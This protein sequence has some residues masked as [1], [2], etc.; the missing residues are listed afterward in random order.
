MSGNL[1]FLEKFT[2]GDSLKMK[3]YI[4]LYLKTAPILFES[5]ERNI[6]DQ[7]W[8]KVSRDAHSLKPQVMYMGLDSLSKLLLEVELKA[9][10]QDTLL[11]KE[12][13]EKA[14]DLHRQSTPSLEAYL[15]T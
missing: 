12:L 6:L 9:K 3:K 13:F 11:L 15:K 7:D 5:L 1:S 10:A 2:E 4:A 14:L 8:D